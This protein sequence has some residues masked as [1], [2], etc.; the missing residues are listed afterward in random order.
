MQILTSYHKS[1][2]SDALL[3]ETN[4][5]CFYKRINLFYFMCMYIAECVYVHH[6]IGVGACGRW[7]SGLDP[8]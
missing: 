8:Q 4:I 6:H 2:K 1:S 7:K 3:V 5:L